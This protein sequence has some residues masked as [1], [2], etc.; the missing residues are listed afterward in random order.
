MVLCEGAVLCDELKGNKVN[1]PWLL[2]N[3]NTLC[4]SWNPDEAARCDEYR[5][6][7]ELAKAPSNIYGKSQ[8][9]QR[10]V[11]SYDHISY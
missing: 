1:L 5:C 2:A 6:L 8:Q 4:C 10:S 9:K 7:S 3:G 11:I